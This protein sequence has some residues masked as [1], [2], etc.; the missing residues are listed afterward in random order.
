[1]PKYG[2]LAASLLSNKSDEN[3]YILP[4]H[5]VSL[6]NLVTLRRRLPKVTGKGVTAETSPL[7]YAVRR[8]RSFAAGDVQKVCTVT[9]N[10]VVHPGVDTTAVKAWVAAEIALIASEVAKG[11]VT[12][13]IYLDDAV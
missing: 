9:V 4:D 6:V 12:G 11:V 8:D 10:T 2:T 7:A 13:D 5:S 3:V 1:M